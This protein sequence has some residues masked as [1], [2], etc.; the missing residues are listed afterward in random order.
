MAEL[1]FCYLDFL[2]AALK[3]EEGVQN[4][5]VLDIYVCFFYEEGKRS[6]RGPNGDDTSHSGQGHQHKC[7]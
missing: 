7:G 5:T 6:E 4:Y 2:L 1:G 3:I